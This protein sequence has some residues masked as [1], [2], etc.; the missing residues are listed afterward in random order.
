[1]DVSTV[2]GDII[3][4]L[5]LVRLAAP[6]IQTVLPATPLLASIATTDII[7]VELPACCAMVLRV[8]LPVGLQ[9]IAVNAQS[10]ITLSPMGAAPLALP[11]VLPVWGE[12][13]AVVPLVSPSTLWPRTASA[14][15][16]TF[17]G[18]NSARVTVVAVTVRRATTSVEV[19][20]CTVR[21]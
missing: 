20:V 10:A 16:S 9:P 4:M 7:S 14:A 18:A 3:S 1:V 11:S 19:H 6:S 17:L 12:S 5:L 13:A 2:N 15:T 8:V 21:M